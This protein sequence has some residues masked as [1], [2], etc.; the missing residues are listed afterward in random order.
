[1]RLSDQHIHCSCSPDCEIPMR[2]MAEASRD[3]GLSMICFTDHVEMDDAHTGQ[4]DPNW[5]QAWP[6]MLSAWRELAAD[7]PAGLEVRLGMELAA[8]NHL[9]ELAMKAAAQPEL[10]FVLGSLHN[11]RGVE[12]F[13][14][15]KYT[16]QAECDRLNR[17][18]MAELLEIAALPC[19]DVMAHVGYTVRYMSLAGFPGRIRPEAYGE[20]LT[21]LF[22]TLISGGRGIEVNTS[23]LRQLGYPF[24]HADIL[25]LYRSLG[26]EIVTIGTDAHCPQ[27]AGAG[28]RQA[29]ALL[30]DLGFKYFTEFKKRQPEFIPL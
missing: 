16:G 12:D 1:M 14:Y 3:A 17:A 5:E 15:Y 24:P 6:G 25:S 4:N 22:R 27:D 23:G 9:P 2:T 18:Y 19:F 13:Y 11:L 29:Q 30:R 20:E 10:D 7:P 26:G 28:I 8:P 21:A